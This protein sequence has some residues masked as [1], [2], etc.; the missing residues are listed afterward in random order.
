MYKGYI[1]LLISEKTNLY[2]MGG[3]FGGDFNLVVW[4]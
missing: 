2:C 3:S 4:I 1:W